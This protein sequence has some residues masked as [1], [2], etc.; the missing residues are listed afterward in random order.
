MLAMTY[1]HYEIKDKVTKYWR[2]TL[3][4]LSKYYVN[5]CEHSSRNTLNDS[6]IYQVL[7]LENTFFCIREITVYI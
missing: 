6:E 2:I 4:L 3:Y 1:M 7:C 5:S